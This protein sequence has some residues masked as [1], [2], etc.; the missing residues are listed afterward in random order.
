MTAKVRRRRSTKPA[1]NEFDSGKRVRYRELNKFVFEGLGKQDWLL[2]RFEAGYVGYSRKKAVRSGGA[3]GG[4]ISACLVYLLE[5]GVIDGAVVAKQIKEKPWL[6][7]QVIVTT[8]RQ[9]LDAAGSIYTPVSTEKILDKVARFKG[10]L[11]YV[12]LPDQVVTIR[13][14]Q[15]QGH[16]AVANIEYV[17]GPYV[18]TAMEVGAIESFLRSNGASGLEQIKLLKYRDGEWPGYMKIVLKDGQVFK[19]EKFYYNYLIPF[20]ITRSC[21]TS[22][23]F[24]NELTDISVGDAWNPKYE[25]L[26]KGF[27]VV[28]GRTTKGMKLLHEM[29]KAGELSLEK[30]KRNELVA[31]HGHMLDFKKRGAFIR[32]KWMKWL[33]HDV[34]K[35]DYEPVEIPISR[36][37]VEV[38]ISGLFV[39]GKWKFVR[40]LVE[41][42]PVE[43]MGVIFN[44]LRLLWKALSRSTKRK[45][46]LAA[47]FKWTS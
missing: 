42:V 39:V 34:P 47:K 41:L 6:A 12:G 19:A 23:D 32:M 44:R 25:K 18:G 7:R 1:V 35:Y 20:Y 45:G 16:E 36:Y 43:V 46:L 21:L 10:K 33:G 26:G 8:R 5:G 24:A 15:G 13:R 28:L 31:M 38:I 22:V 2:G 40:R 17:L 37:G 11:A 27:S 30:K 9:I 29:E 14:L 3:S 4:V